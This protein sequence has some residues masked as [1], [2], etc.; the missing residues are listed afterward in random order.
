MMCVKSIW[1]TAKPVVFALIGWLA[2][3]GA[4]LADKGLPG[5]QAAAATPGDSS[6]Y[7]LPYAIVLVFVGLGVFVVC[8]PVHRRDRARPEEY[9]SLIDDGT[10]GD[11]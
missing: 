6:S 8:R 3:Y 10:M 4:A 5:A 7:V 11:D 1:R 9:T 2:L